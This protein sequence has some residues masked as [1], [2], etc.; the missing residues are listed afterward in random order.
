MSVDFTLTPAQAQARQMTRQFAQTHLS[1]VKQAIDGLASPEERFLA[2]RPFYEEMVKAGF[3]KGIIPVRDGGTYTSLLDVAI[4][5]EEAS[6]GDVNVPCALFS[7]GL[8]LQPIIQK[9]T[10]EQRKRLLAPFLVETGAPLAAFAFSEVGG[11]ANFDDANPQAGI[12]TTA[13]RDGNEWVISGHKHFTTNGYGWS[14]EGADLFTVVCRTDMSVPPEESLAV[15]AV[16]RPARGLSFGKTLD[17]MGHRACLSPRVT[18]DEVRVPIDNIIGKPGDGARILTETFSWT[19]AMV[20]VGAVATMRQAFEAAWAF[21]RSDKRNGTVPIIAH[22]NVGF[23]LADIKMRLEAARYLVWKAAHYFD[24]TGGQGSELPIMAKIYCSELA[25]QVVYDAMRVVG[26]ESYADELPF[27]RLLQDVIALPLYDGG[28]MGVR[29]R[30]LH[31]LLRD[32][33]YD[34]LAAAENRVSGSTL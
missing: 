23:M 9:G 29:R 34:P 17:T 11:T 32:G 13:R 26:V 5:G 30:Q 8:G 18:F 33:A 15:I 14:G 19:A 12:Q 16:P 21:A 24:E 3:M 4:G 6:I 2:I 22:Q 1:K 28:N 25:V 20:G 27:T 7:S 10:P 31:N